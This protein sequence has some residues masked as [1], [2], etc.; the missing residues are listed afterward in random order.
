MDNLQKLKLNTFVS[1]LNR[2]VLMLSGL[3]LPRIIL[4]AYGSEVNGLVNSI[5]QFLS[6]ITFLDLGVGSVVQS[7]LYKPLAIKDGMQTSRILKAAKNYFRSI[8]YI[9]LGYVGL[10][11]LFYPIIIADKSFNF[12]DIMLLIVAISISQFTQYYF[13][14]INEFLLNADQKGYIQSGTEII[15]VILNLVASIFLIFVGTPI[16]I[17]K[18]ATSTIFLIRPIYLYYYVRRH[19][20]L[21]KNIQLIEDPLPQKWSGM[22]QHIAYSIQSSTDVTVLTIFSSLLNI[23]IYSIY[24][25]VI[26]AIKLLISSFTVGIQSF[27]GNLLATNKISTLNEM[28]TKME[29]GLHTLITFIY[30]LAMVLIVPF[31]MVYT[32][33]VK[34]VNYYQPAFAFWLVL[35]GFFFSLRIPYQAIVFANGDFKSTQL[36]SYIEAGV[37]IVSSIILVNLIGLTGVAVGSFLAMIY[38]IFYLVWYLSKKIVYRRAQ[39]FM[40]NLLVDVITFLFIYFVGKYL[41]TIFSIG[42]FLEWIIVSCYVGVISI[43]FVFVINFL[44]YKETFKGVIKQ[45]FQFKHG[46]E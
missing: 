33:G 44:F 9:L 46:G 7:A 1:L 39:I 14:I 20:D 45:I 43:I 21:D 27:F 24:S 19:Y 40:K 36:S 31:V 3:I 5:G 34:D 30:S 12:I 8:S 15:V 41:L 6:I 22:G 23:S 18:L 11:I 26:N 25:L 2:M 10:L 16:Y 29:W 35:S 42:N 28:F 38:R 37:N 17:V 13:G 4:Q 32:Q